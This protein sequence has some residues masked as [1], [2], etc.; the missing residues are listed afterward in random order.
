MLGQVNVHKGLDAAQQAYRQRLEEIRANPNLS[1]QGQA[2]EV[3]EVYEAHKRRMA[4]MRAEVAAELQSTRDR[5]QRRA[6]GPLVPSSAS[7]ADKATVMMAY[8]DALE[9]AETAEST[10]TGRRMLDRAMRTGD[11]QLARAVATV[12]A[13]R[14]WS[15]VLNAYVDAYPDIDAGAIQELMDLSN[16]MET[17]KANMYEAMAYSVTRPPELKG[18]TRLS[19]SERPDIVRGM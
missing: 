4:E 10:E 14:G 19:G 7:E 17:S 12:S 11:A 6:F 8:R 18:P 2:A 9:K 1:D 3:T 5:A 15:A 13:E 16:P